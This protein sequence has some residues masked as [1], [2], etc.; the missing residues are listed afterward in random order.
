MILSSKSIKGNIQYITILTLLQKMSQCGNMSGLVV[1]L[2]VFF[3][4]FANKNR[5]MYQPGCTVEDV[6]YNLQPNRR[7]SNF[8]QIVKALY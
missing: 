1:F 3:E 5:E 4:N 6:A 7:L 2:G 8:L